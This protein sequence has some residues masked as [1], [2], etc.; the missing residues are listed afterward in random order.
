M[1]ALQCYNIS[2]FAIYYK[3]I[4]IYIAIYQPLTPVDISATSIVLKILLLD[5]PK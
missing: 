2:N 4:A 3:I 1:T 5:M